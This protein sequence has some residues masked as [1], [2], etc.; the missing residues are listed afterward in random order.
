M[1]SSSLTLIVAA[2]VTHGIGRDGALP[3]KLSR[4]MAYFKRVT[5]TA[6]EGLRNSVIM[7]RNTWE[8]IPRKFRPLAGRVNVVL[9]S[10]ELEM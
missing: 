5:S 10:R 1:S 7:G 2:T 9:S 8:S 3:W 6:P 4:E